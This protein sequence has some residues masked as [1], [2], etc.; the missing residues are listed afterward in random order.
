MLGGEARLNLDA[1][2]AVLFTDPQVATDGYNEAQ[3]RQLGIDTD[4]RTLT[5]DNVPHALANFDTRG[6]I[7]LVTEAGS[8]RL[9]G[10][11][12]VTT[13]AGEIIQTAAIAIRTQMTS[14]NTGRAVVPVPDHGGRTETRCANLHQRREFAVLLCRV[15]GSIQFAQ[16]YENNVKPSFVDVELLTNTEA[17]QNTPVE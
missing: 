17:K 7:K 13:D 5:L 6:F 14:A 9:L 16:K 1:M 11:Q 8:G 10:V 12:A 2:P 15:A 4:S 3:A